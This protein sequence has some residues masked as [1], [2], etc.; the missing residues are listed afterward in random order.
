MS[1]TGQY[2][3][4]GATCGV[5]EA[6]RLTSIIIGAMESAAGAE[7]KFHTLSDA[8]V[9]NLQTK[10]NNANTDP[11]TALFPLGRI[12]DNVEDTVEDAVYVDGTSGAR[13][14][15]RAG[16]RN[17]IFYLMN[18][19]PQ[20]I[21]QINSYKTG[22]F[23]FYEI[24]NKGGLTYE[25]DTYSDEVKLIPIQEGSI[26]ASRVPALGDNINMVKVEF[27]VD[28]SHDP[29]KVRYAS[30]D[31]LTFSMLSDVNV[32]A[33]IPVKANL[34]SASDSALVMEI[35]SSFGRGVEGLLIGD[36]TLNNQTTD[37]TVT[38]TS[39][40]PD[41]VKPYRYTLAYSTG[42]TAADV[43]NPTFSKT[44]YYTY[45]SNQETITAV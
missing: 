20:F 31:T 15:V 42:V 13:Y 3:S 41:G 14:F 29:S 33:L 37:A 43:L 5:I 22:K 24:D 6:G 2:E 45:N 26:H 35:K 34:I 1:C 21:E 30:K 32:P 40:T 25:T 8:T 4:F 27:T 23:G 44:G 18:A 11:S 16:K 7:N 9:A 19:S 36:F 17:V 38:L 28:E 10:I 39:V 12:V